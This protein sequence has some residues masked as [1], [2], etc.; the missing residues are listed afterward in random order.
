MRDRPFRNA[1]AAVAVNV[2]TED[3]RF[4]TA[5]LVDAARGGSP[6][7][8]GACWIDPG[9]PVVSWTADEHTHETYYVVAGRLRVSWTDADADAVELSPEDGFYFPPGRTYSLENVGEE[10]VFL[11]YGMT[12]SPS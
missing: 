8:L 12:P 10:T 1:L 9:A 2:E 5:V 11:V 4:R 3:G 6:L 7:L